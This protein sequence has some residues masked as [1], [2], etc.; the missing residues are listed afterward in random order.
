MISEAFFRFANDAGSSPVVAASKLE[1]ALRFAGHLNPDFGEVMQAK[2]QL[3]PSKTFLSWSEFS[4]LEDFY[5]TVQLK[6]LEEKFCELDPDCT[7]LVGAKGVYALLRHMGFFPFP[8][9]VDEL[10][11]EV[12]RGTAPGG[13]RSAEDIVN[14]YEKLQSNCGFTSSQLEPLREAFV[15]W[16]RV[17]PAEGREDMRMDHKGLQ[18]ALRWLQAHHTIPEELQELLGDLDDDDEGDEDFRPLQEAEF[19]VIVR[20][21]RTQE[22]QALYQAFA[23][24]DYDVSGTISASEIIGLMDLMH[25]PFVTPELVE[26]AKRRCGLERFPELIFEDLYQVVYAVKDSHGLSNAEAEEIR[27]AWQEYQPAPEAGL[28]HAEILGALRWQGYPVSVRMLWQ[29]EEAGGLHEK[30]AL[31]F[32]EFIWLIVTFRD[33]KAPHSDD[34]ERRAR[35]QDEWRETFDFKDFELTRYTKLFENQDIDGAGT[36]SGEALATILNKT[37]LVKASV[38]ERQALRQSLMGLP[39]EKIDLQGVLKAARAMQD[40]VEWCNVA[41]EAAAAKAC[42]FS[43]AEVEDSRQIFE[44]LDSSG[45]GMILHEDLIHSLWDI[46]KGARRPEAVGRRTR[47]PTHAPPHDAPFAGARDARRTLRPVASDRDRRPSILEEMPREES[48]KLHGWLQEADTDGSGCIDFAEFLRLMFVVQRENWCNINRAAEKVVEANAQAV[49]RK[50]VSPLKARAGG[51]QQDAHEA[52]AS[53]HPHS[54]RNAVLKRAENMFRIQRVS[55][56][57]RASTAIN[58][59]SP[60]ATASR[61]TRITFAPTA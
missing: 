10:L 21:S 4:E 60:D 19:L 33:G 24:S 43:P 53:E 39:A 56:K 15:R 46:V 42:G 16:A 55:L 7:G 11:A 34:P 32:R 45:M 5:D 36:I 37:V 22:V 54:R 29:V 8:Q 18:A 3:F 17:A 14:M 50:T 9:L 47:R 26:E 12:A 2:S 59:S 1:W 52:N 20:A 38:D 25:I 57:K 51:L 48:D 44:T 30:P 23:D 49:R 27:E 40:H 61:T 58:F 41:K 28:G 13:Q 6:S 31:S 35:D